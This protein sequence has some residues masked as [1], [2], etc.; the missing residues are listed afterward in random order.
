MSRIST[1]VLDTSLGRPAAQIPIRLEIA[2]GD[3]F[4]LLARHAT[5]ADG[6]VADLL[7]GRP[8]EAATYRLTFDTR[9]YFTARNVAAFYPSVTVL[10]EITHPTQH[11]HV[12]LLLCPFGYSTYR[13]S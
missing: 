7:A 3:A 2:A 13:G 10:F 11:H 8:L 6:R 9:A 5:D 12:P 4:T 1:H